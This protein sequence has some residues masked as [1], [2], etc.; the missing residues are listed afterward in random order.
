MAGSSPKPGFRHLFVKRK[1]LTVSYGV[2]K[3][4]LKKS[5][6][7]AFILIP[8][9]GINVMSKKLIL[10]MGIAVSLSACQHSSND[11]SITE[12]AKA[13]YDA[14]AVGDMEAW[15]ATQAEDVRW[16]MP[17]GFPYG[18]DYVGSQAV[19]EGVFSPIGKLWPDFKVEA[20]HFHAA[21]NV[22]FIETRMTAGGKTSAALH[23]GVIV[24][25]KF[26]EF[27]AFDDT[28]FMMRH[29]GNG[30]SGK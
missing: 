23:K 1:F 18:G 4:E 21:G 19:M 26:A 27:Q 9:Q 16:R 13:S 5:F 24:D 8:K 30:E 12:V 22:V 6:V 14:F 7:F 28:G 20:L 17:K 25:G 10:V 11:T 2:S 29:A 3:M 15:A